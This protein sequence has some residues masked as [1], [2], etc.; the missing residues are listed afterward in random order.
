MIDTSPDIER[1][2]TLEAIRHAD[3]VVI[4]TRPEFFDMAS[5][6]ATAKVIQRERL[7]EGKTCVVFNQVRPQTIVAREML[8][9]SGRIPYPTL[10]TRIHQRAV[11]SKANRFGWESL[12]LIERQEVL[13]LC[14]ELLSQ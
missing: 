12:S 7:P 11:Y 10:K 2:T 13:E 14:I 9:A 1:P 5:T 6:L 3:L 4:V 8:E